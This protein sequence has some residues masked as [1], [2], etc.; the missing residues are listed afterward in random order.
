MNKKEI[1]KI[2]IKIFPQ[3]IIF[4]CMNFLMKVRFGVKIGKGSKVYINSLFGGHNAVFNNTEIQ[5]SEI[6]FGTYVASSSTIRMSKIGKFCSIA[7]NVKIGVGTHPSKKFVSTSP[8][9]YSTRKNI[10]F[11][12]VKEQKFDDH[13]YTDS[14]KKHVVEVG[15]D[16][17]IASNVL[18]VD[19]IKIGDGAIIGAGAV[20]TKDVPNYAVVG[21]VPAKVIRY[22]FEEEQIDFLNNFKWWDKD[23]SWIK[24]NYESFSDIELFINQNIK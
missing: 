24:D 1:F 2:L 13:L 6:G 17:W 12:F 20:V 19:G 14:Q 15:N 22:R 11:T 5:G 23:F 16:V 21:G 10:D 4:G 8:I 18:I 7:D 9:F 3:C